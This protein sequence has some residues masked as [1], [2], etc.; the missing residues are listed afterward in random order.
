MDPTTTT[1]AGNMMA[2]GTG[3]GTGSKY[4]YVTDTDGSDSSES[5]ASASAPEGSKE[6]NSWRGLFKARSRSSN[7]AT[8]ATT[9]GSSSS[10][11]SSSNGSGGDNNNLAAGGGSGRYRSSEDIW[12]LRTEPVAR[13]FDLHPLRDLEEVLIDEKG[14]KH[15]VKDLDRKGAGM[16][17]ESRGITVAKDI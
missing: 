13:A 15:R 2:S 7:T 11:S 17:V 12:E 10:S 6:E 14:R 3:T 4:A 16:K 8:T 9:S 1:T 5:V